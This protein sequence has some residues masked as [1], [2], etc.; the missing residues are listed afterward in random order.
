MSGITAYRVKVND[1]SIPT[2]QMQ[3]TLELFMDFLKYHIIENEL[4]AEFASLESAENCIKK[5]SQAPFEVSTMLLETHCLPKLYFKYLPPDIPLHGIR[6]LFGMI[7]PVH[8][9]KLLPAKSTPL[10]FRCGFINFYAIRDVFLAGCL[11]QKC[12]I[13]DNKQYNVMVRDACDRPS[14]VYAVKVD[15]LLDEE[16]LFEKFSQFGAIAFVDKYP[17]YAVIGYVNE[18]AIDH[19]QNGGLD[20]SV[21]RVNYT[22]ELEYPAI[23]DQ[24]AFC[25][26]TFVL[27]PE[28]SIV[29]IIPDDTQ[30]NTTNLYIKNL[31]VTIDEERLRKEF[32][33]FGNVQSVKVMRHLSGVSKRIAFVNYDTT[34]AAREAQKHLDK[35][36]LDGRRVHVSFAHR[37]F[38]TREDSQWGVESNYQLWSRS[39]TPPALHSILD[40]L[41]LDKPNEMHHHPFSNSNRLHKSSSEPLLDPM[42]HCDYYGQHMGM[43]S[44][45]KKSLFASNGIHSTSTSSA[46]VSTSASKMGSSDSSTTTSSLPCTPPKSP[47]EKAHE[48]MKHYVGDLLSGI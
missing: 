34:T 35:A 29:E 14:Q 26:N 39:S 15:C 5:L 17:S 4:V 43:D 36:S 32:A 25:N 31:A 41:S 8:S 21:E 3:W 10:K 24:L 12:I 38:G 45:M 16:L 18:D 33:K 42:E 46:P 6:K 44:Y 19:V 27:A 47:V 9:V 13:S 7:G 23:P 2:E 30:D 48:E 37:R 22:P 40:S 11:N 28:Q 1:Y 20:F